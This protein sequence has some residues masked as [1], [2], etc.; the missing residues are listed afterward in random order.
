MEDTTRKK[1]QKWVEEI[2]KLTEETKKREAELW[3]LSAL[4]IL[5]EDKDFQDTIKIGIYE[6]T[7]DP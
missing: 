2:D 6:P 5:L 7:R 4:S 1:L 3:C